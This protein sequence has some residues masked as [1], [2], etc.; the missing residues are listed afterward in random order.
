M[1]S[2]TRK[3]VICLIFVLIGP[4]LSAGN[5]AKKNLPPKDLPA[6]LFITGPKHLNPGLF[7]SV[8]SVL[9]QLKEKQHIVLV[10]VRDANDFEKF[11]IPGSLNIPFFALKTKTFLKKKSLVMINEGFSYSRL[12]QGCLRLR[13]AGFASVSILDGGLRQPGR[14]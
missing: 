4:P 8:E 5:P 3:A 1:S 11:R 6:G 10:D 13:N 14:G 12:E 9:Q 7:I 2:L